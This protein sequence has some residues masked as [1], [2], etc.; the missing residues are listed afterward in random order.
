[1][2]VRECMTKTVELASPDMTILEAACKMRDGDFGILPVGQNDRLVGMVTDRDIAIRATAEGKD[3]N[4]TKVRDVMSVGTLY[5]YDD[6]T[7]EEVAKNMGENQVRRLPVLNREKRLVG[8]LS[9]GDVALSE[10][11][12]AADPYCR[13][14]EH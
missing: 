6:Q 1:M 9:L 3:P 12:K 8:I 4:S 5:C 10:P 14:S 13:I 7:L 11:D 2:F